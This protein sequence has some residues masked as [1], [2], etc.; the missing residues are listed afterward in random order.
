MQN[1]TTR[2]LLIDGNYLLK[3]S[4][5]GAKHLYN[6]KGENIGG[7]YQFL[8]MVRKLI[9]EHNINKCIVVWDGENSGRLR[10]DLYD[11]YK[12]T[13]ENKSWYN[14]IILTEKEAHKQ[15]EEKTLLW[16]KTRIQ[17]YLEHLFIRQIEVEYIEGDDLMAKI[18]H[19]RHDKERILIYTNDRDLTSLMVLP[20]VAVYI[21][22]QNLYTTKDNYFVNFDHHIEN[23][24]IIKALCG[25]SSDNI[26]G[27]DGLAEPT[28]LKHFPM[29]KERK[30]SI[31][32]II[33]QSKIINE[34]R[35]KEK[36]K[37]LKV[38]EN[39]VNGVFSELGEMGIE[40]Y[41][42]NMK[43]VDLMNPILNNQAIIECHD[44]TELP[45]D[46]EGRSS[47]EL[48]EMMMDDG[49]LLNFPN[50]NFVSFVDPFRLLIIKE[51][52]FFEENK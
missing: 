31:D 40:H 51:K 5:H 15:E 49:F 48:R 50:Q 23:V 19:L 29:L 41:D 26:K 45:I 9:K 14:K 33:E 20:N 46:I 3:R 42:L 16:Q 11:S 7:L 47:K 27:I 21:A 52:V 6:A 28:L 38:L 22:N 39:I 36:K 32:E 25:C 12:A 34:N 35:K 13:R 18:C 8:V 30:V 43:L 10:Y 2:T 37:P 24:T 4:F 1:I 44:I 17:N